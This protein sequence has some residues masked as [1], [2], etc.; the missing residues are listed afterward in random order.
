VREPGGE[1]GERPEAAAELGAVAGPGQVAVVVGGGRRV[2][3]RGSGKKGGGPKGRGPPCGVVLSTGAADRSPSPPALRGRGVRGEGL[4][5]APM[6]SCTQSRRGT[7][8]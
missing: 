6:G 8:P 3:H 2:G 1:G 7:P 4:R 5:P